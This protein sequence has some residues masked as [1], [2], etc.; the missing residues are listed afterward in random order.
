MPD[1]IG[2]SGMSPGLPPDPLWTPSRP[3]LELNW[4]G[5]RSGSQDVS[6]VTRG[7]LCQFRV[8]VRALMGSQ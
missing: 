4:G 7:R 1:L 8:D 2:D 6:T 5:R 3:P